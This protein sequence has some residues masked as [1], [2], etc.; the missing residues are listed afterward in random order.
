M[1][2]T[3]IALLWPARA[4]DVLNSRIATAL[5][6]AWLFVVAVTINPDCRKGMEQG[7]REFL[8]ELDDLL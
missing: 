8:R 3:A 5:L 2:T 4:Q 7:I 6:A 1:A